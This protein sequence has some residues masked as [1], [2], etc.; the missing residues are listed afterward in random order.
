FQRHG[1]PA[2]FVDPRE[3]EYRDGKLVAKGQE[4]DLVY[5]R[6]LTSEILAREDE[7]KPLLDAYKARVVCVVNSFRAKLLDKKMLFALLQDERIPSTLTA[8]EAAVVKAN[9]PW[10]RRVAEAKTSGPDGASIDLMPWA[11]EHRQELVL[12]PNDSIGARGVV[13]GK[14]LE[15]DAWERA[16]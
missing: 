3:L 5:R 11:L 6:V 14:T 1:I 16:L 7:V 10:T 4:I 13:I 9:V 2:R 8:E 12:K 15:P